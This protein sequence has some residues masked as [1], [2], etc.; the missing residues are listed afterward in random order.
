MLASVSSGARVENKLRQ[1]GLLVR[2]VVQVLTTLE[3]SYFA[4][5]FSEDT[6]VEFNSFSTT[7]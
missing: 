2:D 3:V 1:L 6:I 7:P 5:R 4:I